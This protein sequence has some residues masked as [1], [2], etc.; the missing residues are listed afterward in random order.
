[1]AAPA[2]ARTRLLRAMLALG[3]LAMLGFV[4]G[5]AFLAYLQP[6]MVLDFAALLQMCGVTLSR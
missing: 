6:D 2:P 3:G 4:T 5:W 1:M